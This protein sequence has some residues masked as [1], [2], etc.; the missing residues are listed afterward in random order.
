MAN[1]NEI[2]HYQRHLDEV[3]IETAGGV[4]E[5]IDIDELEAETAR[6]QGQLLAVSKEQKMIRNKSDLNRIGQEG[7]TRAALQTARG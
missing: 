4:Q 2:I 3:C 6:L 7:S 1:V 5:S